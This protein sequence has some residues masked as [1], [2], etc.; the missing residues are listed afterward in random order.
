MSD[1]QPGY[2]NGTGCR[3]G[4]DWA[5]YRERCAAAINKVDAMGPALESIKQNTATLVLLATNMQTSL[6]G[7]ATSK[8]QVDTETM[9]MIIKNKDYV[10]GAVVL[11]LLAVIYFLITGKP[12]NVPSIGGA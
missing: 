5:E 6:I 4:D 3:V 2:M 10:W 8:N 7:P 12:L 9:R 11:V 1:E